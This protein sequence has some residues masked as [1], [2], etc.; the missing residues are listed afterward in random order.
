M[1]HLDVSWISE[2]IPLTCLHTFLLAVYS[3]SD[4]VFGADHKEEKRDEMI[5]K[6]QADE[7]DDERNYPLFYWIKNR[8]LDQV[9]R[10]LKEKKKALH[11][12]VSQDGTSDTQE[13]CIPADKAEVIKRDAAGATAFH[14]AYLFEQYDIARYLVEH[15][16][17]EALLPYDG[18]C[19][20]F[21]SD[22]GKIRLIVEK[23]DMMYSGENILHIA[24]I[25]RNIPETRWLLE[26][27]RDKVLPSRYHKR[28]R[29]ST[30]QLLLE[31][32]ISFVAYSYVFSMVYSHISF[33]AHPHTLIH[34]R[35]MRFTMG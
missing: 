33:D 6:A 20:L 2:A 10:V 27:Y 26:F 3:V 29:F 34:D 25:K 4:V 13:E 12:Y 16:P 35:N 32:T 8:D 7:H 18:D 23:K 5:A 9:K 31:R 11:L 17:T 30:N 22:T 15:Y 28:T 14:I 21:D 24:I 1:F 19:I